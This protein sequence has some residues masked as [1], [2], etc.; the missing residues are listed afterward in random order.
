MLAESLKVQR[1]VVEKVVRVLVDQLLEGRVA[2]GVS[3]DQHRA[4]G[5]LADRQRLLPGL[6]QHGVQRRH[7]KRAEPA[8]QGLSKAGHALKLD[9]QLPDVAVEL[10]NRWGG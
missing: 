5:R 6:L 3:D 4:E 9:A 10:V 2:A 1:D 7:Q 8:P